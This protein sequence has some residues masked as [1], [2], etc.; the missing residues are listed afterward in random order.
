M[1]TTS[2]SV[3]KAFLRAGSWLFLGIAGVAFFVGGR[4]ISEFAKIDLILS[5]FLGLLIA[6]ASGAAAYALK[7]SA[8]DLGMTADSA[9]Q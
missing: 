5:E 6:G 3:L 7:N 4:A 2:R 1:T 9:S 8:D